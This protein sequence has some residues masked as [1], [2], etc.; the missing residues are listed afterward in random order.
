M[1]IKS[2]EKEEEIWTPK[3]AVTSRRASRKAQK[4]GDEDFAQTDKS[5]SRRS[6]R[7]LKQRIPYEENEFDDEIAL[8]TEWEPLVKIEGPME[9]GIEFSQAD[10]VTVFRYS[11]A[12][13][14]LIVVGMCELNNTFLNLKAIQEFN[15]LGCEM[16]Y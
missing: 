7:R 13:W 16:K 5:R 8:D 1:S 3:K 15:A 4:S 9:N 2:E 6:S 12:E 14:T 10:V 11:T